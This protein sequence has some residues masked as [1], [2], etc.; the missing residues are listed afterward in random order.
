MQWNYYAAFKKG[1][2]P[3]TCQN[4][5]EHQGHYAKWNKPFTKKQILYD[6]THMKYLK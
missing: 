6:F 3:V 5:D 4:M 1:E 2:D